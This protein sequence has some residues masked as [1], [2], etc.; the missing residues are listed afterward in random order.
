M[1][2]LQYPSNGLEI[3][4][5]DENK[6]EVEINIKPCF[7]PQGLETGNEDLLWWMKCSDCNILEIDCFLNCG[8]LYIF[9][10]TKAREKVVGFNFA[11]VQ[12]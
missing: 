7:S 12:Y 4:I 5:K 9:S 2:R 1:L 8:S 3:K 11:S 10:A 6:D